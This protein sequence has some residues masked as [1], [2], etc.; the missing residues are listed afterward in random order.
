MPKKKTK[1]L[2]K[3]RA[4]KKTG[5]H[6]QLTVKQE[7]S[8]HL[9]LLHG[10][11]S[12]AYKTAFETKSEGSDLAAHAWTEFN[13]PHIKRRIEV[14]KERAVYEHLVTKDILARE[15]DEARELAMDNGMPAAAVSASLAKGKLYGQITDKVHQ[16]ISGTGGKS[17]FPEKIIIEIVNVD[18]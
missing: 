15:F 10:S 3:T 2:S 14:L 17:L 13:K 6:R 8:V 1:L 7:Q 12:K 16:E 9:Y 4:K 11:K 5:E 18:K